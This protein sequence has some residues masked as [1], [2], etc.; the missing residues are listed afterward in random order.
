MRR[1]A[2]NI[3][4]L[5][6]D[7][8]WIFK[9]SEVKREVR[10]FFK[11]RFVEEMPDRPTLECYGI[12][13]L[14]DVEAENIVVPFSELEIKEAVFDYGSDKAP[15]PDG[16]NFR[17]I[18][19]FWPVLAND[20]VKLL[21]KFFETGRFI[22]DGPLIINEIY[23]WAK[24]TGK[25]LFFFKIDFEKAYDNINWRFLKLIMKQMN[26]PDRWCNWIKGVLHSARSSVLVNGSP[27]FEFNCEK[28]IRQGDT[29]SP[30]S[31]LIVMEGLSSML[32]M[33]CDNGMFDGVQLNND[34]PIISHLLYADDTMVMGKWSQ[35][36]FNVLKR[37][38]R[39]FHLC[40]GLRINLHKSNLFGIGKSVE[41]IEVCANGMGCRSGVFPFKYLG[42][43]VGTNMNRI[44]NWD[45]V[46]DVFKK[47]LSS[48]KASVVSIAGSVILIKLVLESLPS[49]YFLLYKA[50]VTV[51]NKLEVIIKRFLWGR[52]DEKN[53]IHW[54]AWDRVTK[55]IKDGGLGLSKLE[56]NN[57]AMLLKWLWRYR[58]ENGALWRKFVDA[59]H[60]SNRRCETI[61]CNNRF[62]GV[63]SRLVKVG[64]SLKVNGNGF[65]NMVRGVVGDGSTIKFWIDPLHTTEPL[66]IKFPSLFRLEGRKRC[67]MADRFFDHNS[68]PTICWNWK[69]YPNN[70]LEVDELIQ[71]HRVLSGVQLSGREDSWAW[72]QDSGEDF[73][74]KEARKWIKGSDSS[75]DNTIYNWCKWIPSKCNI[76]MWRASLDRIPTK[77]ALLHR[78]VNVGDGLCGL[79]GD[80]DEMVDHFFSGC[81][82]VCEVLDAIASWCKIPR[83]FVFS[84]SDVLHITDQLIYP[85]KKKKIIYGIIIIVCW[86]IWKARNEKVFNRVDSNVV[87]IVSDVKSLGFIWFRSRHKEGS[88]DWR[89]WC[90]FIFPL[91]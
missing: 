65:V 68:P 77:N 9:P 67:T 47:R 61:Q 22:L 35:F 38:L 71:C 82:V 64:Y 76:F 12:K 78:N 74:V 50:P 36:N 58:V 52:C 25:E 31:F 44:S 30:F 72:N 8:K 37:I 16:F 40:S 42:I 51:I 24:K 14:S 62:S 11:Q 48:W 41:E 18:K 46:V 29:I 3:P 4:G 84:L 79:C 59:I 70:G 17:F 73:S 75:V 49:C 15:G 32:R 87:H 80:I 5:N 2:N 63:W 20:F 39:I 43:L 89:N 56:D 26:F 10:H 83:F 45:S 21:Q 57:Y 54:V 91:M 23:S 55:S 1:V 27:T 28:G 85:S 13:N 53:K 34:G 88:I 33:A 19:R 60:G 90:N 69:H 6:V 86:R 66:K 81:R 7:G